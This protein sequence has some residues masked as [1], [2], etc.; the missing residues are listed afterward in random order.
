MGRRVSSGARIGRVMQLGRNSGARWHVSQSARRIQAIRESEE[1]GVGG[2]KRAPTRLA[3]LRSAQ[4]HRGVR[5][6]GRGVELVA[7]EKARSCLFRLRLPGIRALTVWSP[8]FGVS[9][10]FEHPPPPR[11]AP[12]A[13]C[14]T[15]GA[16][17]GFPLGIV[18]VVST[19][20]ALRAPCWVRRLVVGV[21]SAW[22]ASAPSV[23]D[24]ASIRCIDGLLALASRRP[25][26]RAAWCALCLHWCRCAFVA[27][28]RCLFE[29]GCSIRRR[30]VCR[31]CAVDSFCCW[32]SRL[33]SCGQRRL[34]LMYLSLGASWVSLV[35]V[36][37]ARR[38]M[39]RRSTT[40][41]SFSARV[42]RAVMC[43]GLG[44]DASL[45]SIALVAAWD[46]C[47]RL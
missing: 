4:R 6:W 10:T 12:R 14:A 30:V 28:R 18:S 21:D 3:S 42:F 35:S 8:L 32:W 22:R 43:V 27:E 25:F 33:R 46:A 11:W 15:M 13:W 23:C 47:R 7:F 26:G 17:D 1:D 19:L 40:G 41:K 44:E 9:M 24:G 2:R 37:G 36:F 31:L 20:V 5:D 29:S 45:L 34:T 16:Q 39:R 38:L